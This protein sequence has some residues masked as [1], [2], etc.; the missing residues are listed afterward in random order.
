M[1]MVVIGLTICCGFISGESKAQQLQKYN[2]ND[3][4]SVA[5]L[6]EYLLAQEDKGTSIRRPASL[7][8]LYAHHY[9]KSILQ[10]MVRK[11]NHDEVE[12]LATVA[13]LRCPSVACLYELRAIIYTCGLKDYEKGVEDFTRAIAWG[14]ASIWVYR[15]R[16]TLYE[17]LEQ[18]DLAVDDLSN[19]I[20]FFSCTEFCHSRMRLNLRLGMYSKLKVDLEKCLKDN[21]YDLVAAVYAGKLMESEYRFNDAI[22]LYSRVLSLDSQSRSALFC[23]GSLRRTMGEYRNAVDDFSTIISNDKCDF[24]AFIFR[25]YTHACQQKHAEAI[26][27][28]VEAI[29]IDEK[30]I[31]VAAHIMWELKSLFDL[32]AYHSTYPAS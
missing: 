25:G 23:R 6:A 3:G 30:N 2:V 8:H 22:E 7:A 28:Y 20:H 11:S 21:P 5:A 17:I 31:A 13:I 16:A 10:L 14:G 26:T 4:D 18:F 12:K 1:Q 27:D 9:R 15:N 19:A 24:M 29:R 32:A